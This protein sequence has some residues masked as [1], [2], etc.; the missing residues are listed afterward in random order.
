MASTKLRI[1][2]K[3]V[4]NE[5]EL[6]M[7]GLVDIPLNEMAL[8]I[9]RRVTILDLSNNHIRLLPDDFPEAMSQLHKLDLGRNLLTRLPETLGQMCHL[10]QL[11]LYS[12]KI[13]RLPMSIS[14]LDK[15]TWLDV[16]DNPLVEPL[17]K[18]CGDCSDAKECAVCAK[19]IVD[20]MKQV[21]DTCVKEMARGKDADEAMDAASALVSAK[22]S[23]SVHLRQTKSKNKKRSI[24]LST[25]NIPDLSQEEIL[26]IEEITDEITVDD[27]GRGEEGKSEPDDMDVQ[28]PWKEKKHKSSRK[29]QMNPRSRTGIHPGVRASQVTIPKAKATSDW[30][31][32]LSYM[33][34]IFLFTTIGIL[35]FSTITAM[36]V[37]YRV[38]RKHVEAWA[39]YVLP[40]FV[41]TAV[42]NFQLFIQSYVA[43]IHSYFPYFP[44]IEPNF[45]IQAFE[46]VYETIA[47]AFQAVVAWWNS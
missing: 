14:R 17:V 27:S 24:P 41:L 9:Y 2:D 13:Q 16:K 23:K 18:I 15:L 36:I 28:K 5:M 4:G 44:Y 6:S 26:R 31:T 12:N 35:A 20:F 39:S 34:R 30:K 45:F 40:K 1:G 43:L 10:R 32:S 22:S 46:W 8:P 38:I 7:L 19:N 25:I 3:V 42:A 33:L 37:D 21:E 11:D 47:S 29:S